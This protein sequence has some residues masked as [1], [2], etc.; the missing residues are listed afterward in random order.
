MFKGLIAVLAVVC[1]LLGGCNTDFSNPATVQSYSAKINVLAG[2]TTAIALSTAKLSKDDV[3][4]IY[5]VLFTTKE[6]ISGNMH[7]SAE[8]QALF[9]K[10][11]AKYIKNDKAKTIS[12]AVFRAAIT[13]ADSYVSPGVNNSGTSVETAIKVYQQFVIAA[14]SGAIDEIVLYNQQMKPTTAPTS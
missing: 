9:D 13:L 6:G 2:S 4:A 11:S 14:L 10:A 3:S 5:L 8:I 7:S 1:M 12:A